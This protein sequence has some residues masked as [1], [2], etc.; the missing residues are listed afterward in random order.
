MNHNIYFTFEVNTNEQ[1]APAVLEAIEDAVRD[2]WHKDFEDLYFG[3]G[4]KV[5]GSF[6]GR[7]VTQ[8]DIR[9][10]FMPI[11]LQYNV[12]AN[13]ELSTDEREYSLRLGENAEEEYVEAILNDIADKFRWIEENASE[14]VLGGYRVGMEM[15]QFDLKRLLEK[16]G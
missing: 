5:I 13:V 14:V 10:L 11:M 4:W 12:T 2:Y 1:N 15:L 16:A 7:N 6:E 8:T 3:T 9:T